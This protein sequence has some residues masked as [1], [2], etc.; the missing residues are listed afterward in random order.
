MC[1]VIRS[2]VQLESLSSGSS[3]AGDVCGK[4]SAD[5]GI[6]V[7]ITA[8]PVTLSHQDLPTAHG[9]RFRVTYMTRIQCQSQFLRTLFRKTVWKFEEVEYFPGLNGEVEFKRPQGGPS[10]QLA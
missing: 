7:S 9:K 10:G 4:G 3:Q 6:I 8:R 2:S 1:S 5:P